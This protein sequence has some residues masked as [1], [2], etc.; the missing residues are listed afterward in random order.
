MHYICVTLVNNIKTGN[1]MATLKMAK[2]NKPKPF[3]MK[4][5][6]IDSETICGQTALK[7]HNRL[8]SPLFQALEGIFDKELEGDHNWELREMYFS[9]DAIYTKKGAIHGMIEHVF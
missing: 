5:F 7:M 4:V 2:N 3:V 8:D 1:I 6:N 9:E